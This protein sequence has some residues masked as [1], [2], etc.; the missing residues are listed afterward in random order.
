M[1]KLTFN[2]MRYL[3]FTS[4]SILALELAR[5]I[6]EGIDRRAELE[7]L[8]VVLAYFSFDRKGIFNDMP[9]VAFNVM[10]NEYWIERIAHSIG[11]YK[12][13]IK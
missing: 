5:Q 9:S 11:A 10:A 13:K 12:R 4:A 7:K 2:K 3:T 1:S 6:D 8:F